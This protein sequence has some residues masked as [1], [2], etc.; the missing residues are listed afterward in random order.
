MATFTITLIASFGDDI[1][2]IEADDTAAAYALFESDCR[3]PHIEEGYL[4]DSSGDLVTYY[5]A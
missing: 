2:D 5:S 1:R 4:H 3:N